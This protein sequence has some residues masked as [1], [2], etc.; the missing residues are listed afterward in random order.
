V[1]KAPCVA[2]LLINGAA[3]EPMIAEYGRFSSITTTM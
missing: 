1:N 2:N 3:E